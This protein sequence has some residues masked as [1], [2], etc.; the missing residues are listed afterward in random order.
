LQAARDADGDGELTM[1]EMSAYQGDNAFLL[2]GGFKNAAAVNNT[3]VKSPASGAKS[4]PQT[5]QS[6]LV[7]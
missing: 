2:P 7:Q 1:A 3:P 6:G 4:G 5:P